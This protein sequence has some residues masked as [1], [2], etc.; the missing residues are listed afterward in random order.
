M[1]VPI[2]TSSCAYLWGIELCTSYEED[3]Q[4]AGRRLAGK[5]PVKMYMKV[6]GV[7]TDSIVLEEAAGED[8]YEIAPENSSAPSEIPVNSDTSTYSFTAF[9]RVA[10]IAL[11]TMA[12]P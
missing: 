7:K 5:P 11:I 10:P 9:L 3:E 1:R 4:F 2:G 8:D 6:Q 12:S